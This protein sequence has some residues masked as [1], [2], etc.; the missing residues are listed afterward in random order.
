MAPAKPAARIA[1]SAGIAGSSGRLL[2]ACTPPGQGFFRTQGIEDFISPLAMIGCERESTRRLVMSTVDRVRS[3]RLRRSGCVSLDELMGYL[4]DYSD[5]VEQRKVFSYI[6]SP[7]KVF[8][9]S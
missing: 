8:R 4:S 3:G 7:D 5:Y 1:A 6:N 2:V 9:A